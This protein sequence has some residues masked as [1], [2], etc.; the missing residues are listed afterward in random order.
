VSN[1]L[2]V[3]AVTASL[4]RVL[5]EA[6][7]AG[8]PGAVAEATVTTARPE[9][10]A[11]GGSERKGINVYLYQVTPNAAWRNAELPSRREDG[12]LVRRPQ[13]ALDLHYL[14][15][16]YGDDAHLEPQRLLGMAVRTINS[17]PV[18]TRAAVRAA[19]DAAT[20]DD[21]TTYLQFAD[22]AEA[23]ELVRFSPLPLNLEELSKLWSVFFQ[24]PYVLSVA[25]E[26]SVVLIESGEAPESLGLPVLDRRVHVV[27]YQAPA[28]EQVVS[29]GGPNAPVLSS[30]SL[31]IRGRNLVGDVTTVRIGAHEIAAPPGATSE[32]IVITLPA[33]IR[34]GVHAVQILH[35]IG[36]GEPPVP[37]EGFESNVV[38][39]M[40]RPLIVPPAVATPGGAAGDVDVKVELAPK[41][42]KAQRV[43]LLLD[44][45]PG[46]SSRS[47][48][49]ELAPRTAPAEPEESSSVTIATHGVASGEYLVRV[50][51]DGAESPLDVGPDGR[52]KG[53][54]I[55]FP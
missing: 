4:K 2:A 14:L 26:G 43:A 33:E 46:G 42:G 53:P 36:L 54:R 38:P 21:P 17:R 10:A 15:T 29:A 31:R 24:T 47:H 1:Y 30:S 48:R 13:A 9:T 51:V 50:E 6:L 44:E 20:A 45:L 28:I 41:V 35:S 52:F 37:H 32:E 55:V 39:V 11:N 23:I 7:T 22:L 5:D 27:P 3:A 49:F 18:L 12:S 34:A 16:F 8:A 25:Y 40:L 19:M